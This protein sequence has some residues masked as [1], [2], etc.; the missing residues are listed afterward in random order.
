MIP[1][2]V[3][4][5]PSTPEHGNKNSVSGAWRF[6]ARYR[7]R[8]PDL[9]RPFR[10][11][12]PRLKA[13]DPDQLQDALLVTARAIQQGRLVLPA[14]EYEATSLI[15]TYVRSVVANTKRWTKPQREHEALTDDLTSRV[16]IIE[17]AL[18]ARSILR[19]CTR[20]EREMLSAIV[21]TENMTEAAQLLGMI[22]ETLWTRL[23]RFRRWARKMI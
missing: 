22:P 17:P 7:C 19:R 5:C 9:Q 23:R 2:Q 13:I 3:K 4:T 12:L 6:G 14:D 10:L 15:I 11:A 20:F 1:I 21:Q 16:V 8:M 18:Y